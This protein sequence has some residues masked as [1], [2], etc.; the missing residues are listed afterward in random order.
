MENELGVGKGQEWLGGM[1]RRGRAHV[2]ARFVLE[3]Q[4]KVISRQ[5]S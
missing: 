5:A 2:G 1:G 4:G 3:L